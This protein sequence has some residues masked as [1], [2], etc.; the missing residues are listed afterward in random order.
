MKLREAWYRIYGHLYEVKNKNKKPKWVS[1][2][3]DIEFLYQN[4]KKERIARQTGLAYYYRNW[5]TSA[6]QMHYKGKGM[7]DQA[8]RL[9]CVC[10]EQNLGDFSEGG[11]RQLFETV[12]NADY[13]LKQR[14]GR[15]LRRED[16]IRQ[17]WRPEKDE[18]VDDLLIWDRL[19]K[20][21]FDGA[22]QLLDTWKPAEGID[23]LKKA[24]FVSL[25]DCQRDELWEELLLPETYDT[26]QDYVNALEIV[27][28]IR[29]VFVEKR[30]EGLVW[31]WDVR[32][33]KKKLSADIPH[34]INYREVIESL[35]K[36]SKAQSGQ[37][38]YGNHVREYRM[39][40]S[41][42]IDYKSSEKALHILVELCIVLYVRHV[43]LFKEETWGQICEWMYE[44]YP[45]LCLFY[46]L[47]YGGFA[48]F[49]K[50]ISQ[51][52]L[53]SEKL[54][55]ELP[56]MVGRMMR[57]TMQ[58]ECPQEYKEAIFKSLPVLLK[59]VDASVWEEDFMCYYHTPKK[60][61]YDDLNFRHEVD[62]DFVMA[63]LR[64][65]KRPDFKLE[66]IAS[67]LEKGE[68]FGNF[69][70]IV[71]IEAMH[72]LSK[73]QLVRYQKQVRKI[74]SQLLNMSANIISAPQIYV[75]MNLEFL[76]DTDSLGA[77]FMRVNDD[78][79]QKDTTTMEALS[80]Y[81]QK[82]PPLQNKL[83]PIVLSRHDMWN[84][85]ISRDGTSISRGI[86][87]LDITS[88]CRTLELKEEDYTLIFEKL[89][90]ALATIEGQLS[91]E[92]K[93]W[94]IF[95]GIECKSIIKNMW[96]FLREH[97]IML[98]ENKDYEE[99]VKR[100]EAAL[101]L[102][103]SIDGINVRDMLIADKTDSAIGLLVDATESEPEGTFIQNHEVEYVFIAHKLINRS[104]L[105]LDSCMKHFGWMVKTYH[106]Q[107]SSDLF[108]PLLGAILKSYK[109][110]FSEEA[111]T[112][113][114]IHAKKDVFEKNLITIYS[115]YK[116]WGG[117]DEFWETYSPRYHI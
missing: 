102:M 67:A 64:Y 43:I 21:D 109:P 29:T 7:P 99:V 62:Y 9:L 11:L 17:R 115:F 39:N 86:P 41:S 84:T 40:G 12:K 47:Q 81:A 61:R 34:L 46:S 8:L 27:P 73:E 44:K 16:V 66:V 82:Y 22:K 80:W 24:Q 85:G 18:Q 83:R 69:N 89:K 3:K 30:G 19:L 38:E 28:G 88:I 104:S 110:Y 53:Y 58:S 107:M 51:L 35:V 42:S 2:E 5:I 94:F 37:D 112:W 48:K 111:V 93:E 87:Y 56:V 23:K 101:V 36:A 59:G 45:Y 32:D 108:M 105:Y 72:G 1:L 76:M 13:G 75:L 15:L 70:N 117:L 26:I 25:F 113:N 60:Q 68:G 98:S 95:I 77:A 54:K 63:G 92:N 79:I 90:E 114:L 100:V 6:L 103:F 55:D 14:I 4:T 97:K 106:K 49:L 52:Y 10:W 65:M 96:S 50:R 20:L 71:V 78:L 33:I 116:Q 31:D 74:R 91:K 57:A